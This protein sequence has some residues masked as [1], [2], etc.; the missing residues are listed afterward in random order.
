MV[1]FPNNPMGFPTKNDHFG[2]FCGYRHLRKHP[3]DKKLGA[4]NSNIFGIFTPILGEMVQFD[5]YF[6]N[7][8]KPP[9][10]KLYRSNTI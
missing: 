7:G 6:S 3:D 8:L 5:E 10:R 2:V 1:G 4:G 9:T